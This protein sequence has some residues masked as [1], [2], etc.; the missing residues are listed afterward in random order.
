M[1][2]PG[3]TF[4]T[5]KASEFLFGHYSMATSDPAGIR[6]PVTGLKGQ[7]PAA[8]RQGRYT[9]YRGACGLSLAHPK[10]IDVRVLFARRLRLD[11]QSPLV[12]CNKSTLLKISQSV[13]LA[14]SGNSVGGRPT[15]YLYAFTPGRPGYSR[16]A[17]K[18]S[19]RVLNIRVEAVQRAEGLSLAPSRVSRSCSVALIVKRYYPHPFFL[20][21][22][23]LGAPKF[24]SLGRFGPLHASLAVLPASTV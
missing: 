3:C 22:N 12:C 15:A 10:S 14:P 5:I 1:H 7:C 21:P 17:D 8:R 13:K 9:P 2:S 4:P 19:G 11:P 18:K 16:Q 6:T 20:R 23:F 24:I